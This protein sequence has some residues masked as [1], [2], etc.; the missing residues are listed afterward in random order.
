VQLA[1]VVGTLV[2]TRKEAELE[3]LKLLIVKACDFDGNPTG[4]AVV[5]ADA[6]G[7]GLGEVVLYASGSS[8][9]QTVMTKDRPV[10]ATIMAIVD[11]VAIDGENRY[12]KNPGP[13]QG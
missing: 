5:A 9:R 6:V 12:V 7:A 4:A 10:D 13:G 1:K 3:G 8:A 11:M 2:A